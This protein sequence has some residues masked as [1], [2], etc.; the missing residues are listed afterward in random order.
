MNFIL[1]AIVVLVALWLF[2]SWDKARRFNQAKR[3][4]IAEIEHIRRVMAQTEFNPTQ[5]P[6]DVKVSKPVKVK[7]KSKAK[8]KKKTK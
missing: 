4:L 6:V 1:S 8:P 3:E 5:R 2:R 7:V